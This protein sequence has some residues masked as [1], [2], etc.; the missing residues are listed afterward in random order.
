M[1]K[2]SQVHVWNTVKSALFAVAAQQQQKVGR[3]ISL[4]DLLIVWLW[5]AHPDIA[6]AHNVPKP[7]ETEGDDDKVSP[8]AA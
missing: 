7:D 6:E 4:N 1:K 3:R 8:A 5:R 2:A